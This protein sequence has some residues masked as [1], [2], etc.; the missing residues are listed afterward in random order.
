MFS[1]MG[2]CSSLGVVLKTSRRKTTSTSANGRGY[3]ASHGWRN[4]GIP[5][6]LDI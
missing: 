2:V 1:K 5:S 3:D 4:S 6:S